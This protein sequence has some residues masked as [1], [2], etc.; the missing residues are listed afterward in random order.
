MI[1][2]MSDKTAK[3]MEFEKAWKT[4]AGKFFLGERVVF[5]G[6]NLHDEFFDADWMK[7]LVYGSTGRIY[8]DNELKLLNSIWVYTNYPDPRIWNNRV[9]TLA[10]NAKSSCCLAI[11]AAVA[12]SEAHIYGK[13]ADLRAIQFLLHAKSEMDKGEKLLH[14][15]KKEL[16]NR[17]SIGGFGRPLIKGDER[18]PYMLKRAK[19][20][21]LDDG[22]YLA[23]LFQIEEELKK[24]KYP[25]QMNYGGL[26]AALC[27]DLGMSAME[28]YLWPTVAF[29]AAMVPLYAE[30]R[31]KPAG[32]FFPF[33][34][35]SVI[36]EGNKRRRW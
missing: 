36:Y 28:F 32:S 19:L 25:F 27:A 35:S 17:R 4:N 29:T 8:Q 26:V 18:I 23:L 20:L 15:I 24:S 11:G 9:V 13:Q 12:V 14:L 6:K 16:K 33:R 3:L 5:R 21:G 10:A 7:L 2:I 31:A 30:A 34:C 22:E 1:R